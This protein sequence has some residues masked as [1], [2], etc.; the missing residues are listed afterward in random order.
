MTKVDRA[1]PNRDP[2]AATVM[3]LVVVAGG[4]ANR[5]RRT[6]PGACVFDAVQVYYRI[7]ISCADFGV[8]MHVAGMPAERMVGRLRVDVAVGPIARMFAPEDWQRAENAE[9]GAVFAG[10]AGEVLE[11]VDR[12]PGPG[13]GPAGLF[14]LDAHI[15]DV[16]SG[17]PV[18]Y[19]RVTATVRRG[20]DS[21][22][23]AVPLVPVARPHKGVAGL[24]YG[25]NVALDPTGAYQVTVR[26]A[27][28]PLIGIEPVPE[29][30]FGLDFGEAR[31]GDDE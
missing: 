14:N 9:G 19:L 17:H 8:M 18:P 25:N 31:G 20:S 30:E 16:A 6:L 1:V 28:S 22:L 11:N 10:R 26:I 27:P 4:V 7:T 15:R 23:T 12:E 5:H 13:G 2:S 24:H 21:V 29:L 3:I